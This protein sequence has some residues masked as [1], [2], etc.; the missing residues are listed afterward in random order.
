MNS[1]F[2]RPLLP[3]FAIAALLV[4]GCQVSAEEGLPPPRATPTEPAPPASPFEGEELTGEAIFV[5][6]NGERYR[7]T[8]ELFPGTVPLHEGTEGHGALLTTYANPVGMESLERGAA[9]M[10]PRA[11]I[12]VEDYLA[13]STLSTISVM[14][15]VDDPDPESGVWRFTRFEAAG[16]VVAGLADSCRGCHVLEP[17]LLFGWEL[18]VPLPIDSTGAT[19]GASGAP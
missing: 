5:W 12:A 9:S 11:V 17:D 18:G 2:A 3:S 13:D 19:S 8:W 1:R 14:L 10:P 15:R 16:E 7:E 4:A 6:L